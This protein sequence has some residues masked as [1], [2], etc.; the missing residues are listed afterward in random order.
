MVNLNDLSR[1]MRPGGS[2]NIREAAWIEKIRLL[3]RSKGALEKGEAVVH[4]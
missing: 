1:Q 4:A 3:C 2:V